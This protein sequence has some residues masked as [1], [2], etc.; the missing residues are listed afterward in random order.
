MNKILYVVSQQPTQVAAVLLAQVT[1][2]QFFDHKEYSGSAFASDWL[3]RIET[4]GHTADVT[5]ELRVAVPYDSQ[6]GKSL[7]SEDWEATQSEFYQ[8][9]TEEQQ[10]NASSSEEL[11]TSP[12]T[13]ASESFDEVDHSRGPVM[14]FCNNHGVAVP[15]VNSLLD[16]LNERDDL[17]IVPVEIHD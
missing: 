2:N 15:S 1:T 11:P 5:G 9:F 13:D 4:D 3:N 6:A 16:I 8:T 7:L 12:L 17:W 10:Q 14:L